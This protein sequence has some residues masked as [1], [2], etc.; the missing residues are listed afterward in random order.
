MRV[1]GLMS[2]TSMDGI[3]AAL[4]D[5]Q[6]A[7][8]PR[9]PHGLSVSPNT[10]CTIPYP[11][12]VQTILLGLPESGDLETVCGLNAYIGTLLADS[13]H[14]VVEH[15]DVALET[16]DLVS[17]HGQTV[18]HLPRPRDERSGVLVPSTL[19][20]GELDV[21]AE[22]TG[23]PTIGDF[24]PRDMAAGGEGAP[25]IPYV[26]Y[27]LF[28]RA[29][30]HRV[31][32]NLG[33]IANITYLPAGSNLQ[34]LVAFDTGPANMV[35]DGLVRRITQGRELYDKN[36]H[37]ASHGNVNPDLLAHMMDHP[38]IEQAPPKSTGREEFGEA[39]AASIMQEAD[40]RGV[41]MADR[42]AT[43]TAFTVRSIQANVEHHLGSVDEIIASG[44]G[45]RNPVLMEQ[46]ESAF[47]SASVMTTDDWG[48]PAE[49]KEAIGFAVLGYQS[50]H[51]RPNNAPAATG[52]QRPVVMGKLAWGAHG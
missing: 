40:R 47:P 3:T 20:I 50:H 10:H 52:A 8:D 44:G 28:A 2:G 35:I 49:A 19:Q 23:V 14:N 46:L 39:Y 33:G 24:R 38:F 9:N 4:T 29:D 6:D 5:I 21:I 37:L 31:M 26:D 48:I 43:A 22:A 27:V 32:L 17:S 18:Y 41:D 36:G 13:V 15:A 34:D 1:I 11:T 16:V 45:T 51:R 25:L 12:H 42:V 7:P 30:T